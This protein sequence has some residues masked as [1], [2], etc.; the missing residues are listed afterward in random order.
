MNCMRQGSRRIIAAQLAD[1]AE[2]VKAGATSEVAYAE[3][4]ARRY[5]YSKG[6]VT[7]KKRGKA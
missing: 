2:M 1:H 3:I 4:R 5:T 6:M 7:W